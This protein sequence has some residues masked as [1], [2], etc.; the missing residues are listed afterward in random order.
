MIDDFIARAKS[1]CFY[2]TI[3]VQTHGSQSSRIIDVVDYHAIVS[4]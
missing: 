4:L 3:P 2:G 1:V